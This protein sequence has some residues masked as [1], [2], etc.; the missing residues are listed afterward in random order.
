M[1]PTITALADS[2]R[3]APALK[4]NIVI[5]V[6]D[7]L[8]WND[9]GYHGGK[10][11]TPHIDSLARNGIELNRFYSCPLCSPTRAGLMTGRYPIRFGMQRTVVRPWE[12]LGIPHEEEL[13]PEMLARAGY[14]RRGLFGKWHLGHAARTYHPLNHG[15]THFYG[16]YNGFVDYFTHVRDGALDWHRGY[17]VSHDEGYATDLVADEA[18]RFIRESGESRPFFLCVAFGAPHAPNQAPEPYLKRYAHLQEPRLTHAAMVTCMDDAIGRILQALDA[19]GIADDTLVL[20]FSDNGGQLDCGASNEPLRGQKGE[21]FEGGIRVPAVI[22]WPG[23]LH[24]GRRIDIVAGYIDV[25]PTLQRIVGVAE[26]AGRPLDGIDLL[27]VLRGEV[28]HP[29]REWYSYVGSDRQEQLAITTGEW[30]LVWHGPT[31]LCASSE[32]E[33]AISLFRIAADP[34]E[35]TDLAPDHPEV[36][37]EL[38][39]RLKTFRSVRPAEGLTPSVLPPKGWKPPKDW[40]IPEP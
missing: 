7:D 19:K 15:F 2:A 17:E 4:L 24:G 37:G 13:L 30:K 14:T 36:V 3:A 27:D 22:R 31:I 33:V 6:A 8:G 21:L 38:L 34:N 9:V 35:T 23:G 11:A 12:K 39:K 40:E 29:E 1:Y 32:E 18:V 28:P 20:F 26:R 25:F 5:I 10:I 16:H